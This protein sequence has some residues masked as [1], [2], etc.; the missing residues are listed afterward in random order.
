MLLLTL[1]LLTDRKR[2]ATR[3]TS[4]AARD[5]GP[6]PVGGPGPQARRAGRAR[7][8]A[9]SA[10]PLTVSPPLPWTRAVERWE[11][12]PGSTNAAPQGS[13]RR[14]GWLGHGVRPRR[15][16]RRGWAWPRATTPG[17]ARS[18]QAQPA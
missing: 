10:A 8:T 14:A 5:R 3:A 16:W 6:G 15:V 9:A 4:A 18:A 12:M 17:R 11:T 2:L 13:W 1:S 7:P